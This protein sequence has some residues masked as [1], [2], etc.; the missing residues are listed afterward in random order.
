[1]ALKITDALI[2]SDKTSDRAEF[3]PDASADGSGAWIVTGHEARLFTR[4][5][6][7]TAMMLAQ[8]LAAGNAEDGRTAAWRAELGLPDEPD[9]EVT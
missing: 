5:Q 7:I 6:A 2:T 8:H 3:R 4:N 9:R 1:M